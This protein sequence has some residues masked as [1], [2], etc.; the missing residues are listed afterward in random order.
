[1]HS[2]PCFC[3]LGTRTIYCTVLYCIAETEQH[4]LPK[5]GDNF[6]LHPTFSRSSKQIW[7]GS[8][9]TTIEITAQARVHNH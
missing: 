6:V 3:G 1:M 8:A 2:R 5:N 9:T 7:L 4:C